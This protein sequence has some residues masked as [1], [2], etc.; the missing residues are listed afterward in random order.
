MES[1]LISMAII[2]VVAIVAP[3]LAALIPK[4]PVPE[5]VFLL[6]AGAILGPH[7]M[8]LIQIN[9]S[10][11]FFSEFGLA[12]LFLLAGYEINPQELT[13]ERGKAALGTWIISFFLAF[14]MVIFAP[15]IDMEFKG[16]M[17]L[18]IAM[19][20]TALGTLLPILKERG[21][22]DTHIGKTVLA[23]GT[24][25]EVM[26]IVAMAILLSTR[27]TLESILILILFVLIALATAV[28][29]L[30]AQRV[31]S[32]LAHFI[33]KNADT[34]AQTTMRATVAL[35]VGLVTVASLFQLD[36]VLGAFAAGF[37]LRFTAP[38]ENS[39]LEEKLDGMAYG[40]LIPLFFV[41]SGANIDLKA[42]IA[43][44][45]QLI[46]FVAGLLVVRAI[47]A[48]ASTYL[49]SEDRKKMTYR[50]RITSALYATTALPIIVAVTHVA[51]TSGLM[52]EQTA[53]VLVSAGAL[54]VLLMPIIT[55]ITC[56][57]ADVHPLEATKEIAQHPTQTLT[58]LRTHLLDAKETRTE[59]RKVMKQLRDQQKEKVREKREQALELRRALY[60]SAQSRGAAS[61]SPTELA[62]SRASVAPRKQSL[63]GVSGSDERQA[64]DLKDARLDALREDV[65]DSIKVTQ[66]THKRIQEE[67][68]M[69]MP[70]LVVPEIDNTA[71]KQEIERRHQEHVER[72][73]TQEE[74][75]KQ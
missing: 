21:L 14:F 17:A 5:V 71:L 50:D 9:E 68:E 65:R 8:G 44:P 19:T 45:I 75:E 36:V 59:Y 61:V 74:R 28:F 46:G 7:M 32:A 25:G 38:D 3:I 29:P 16:K 55:A 2:A 66:E 30:K 6:V 15:F 57:V 51:T 13:S 10:I 62:Y 39:D 20:S 48:Y 56:N 34:T 18:V 22:I 40:F 24:F 41:V 52:G 70:Q 23:H 53:S 35:L 31:G 58:V 69:E 60:S 27:S 43:E 47:P 73:A 12:F 67:R 63:S 42:V 72:E 1:N 49:P 11:S 4:K 54:T 37:I 64:H 33:A 26:P